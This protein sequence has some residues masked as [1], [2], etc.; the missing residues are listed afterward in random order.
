MTKS[1]L[2]R[3]QSLHK[4][5]L[6]KRKFIFKRN[7]TSQFRRINLKTLQKITVSLP[8]GTYVLLPDNNLNL[9]KRI[10]NIKIIFIT[11]IKKNYFIVQPDC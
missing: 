2:E 8:R 6:N 3:E 5:N 7:L 1:G 9:N 4:E 11:C 10:K